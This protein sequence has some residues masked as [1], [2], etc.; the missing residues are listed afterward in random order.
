MLVYHKIAGAIYQQHT[1]VYTYATYLFQWSSL[2]SLGS[3]PTRPTDKHR[4]CRC[5]LRTLILQFSNTDI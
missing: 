2:V 4:P 3:Y 5:V 1:D